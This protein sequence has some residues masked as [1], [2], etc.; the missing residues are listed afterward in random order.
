MTS[1]L[2]Q[3]SNGLATFGARQLR[4]LRRL[5]DVLLEWADACG[6]DEIA[7]PPLRPVA[8]LAR[9]DYFV[10][11]PHLGLAAAPVRHDALSGIGESVR[12]RV[13]EVPPGMLDDARY[14][15]PSAACYPVYSHLS[16]A[17]L[18][19]PRRVTTVQRC[20]RNEARYEG[21]A[22]LLAFTMREV[23]I[24]GA[25][26][27]V[28]AFLASARAWILRF[29]E[30][31]GLALSTA[32]ATDPF[33]AAAGDR[34]RMQ[35]LFPVKEEFLD[36][37]VAIASVNSHLNFFGER[38]NIRTADGAHAFSGCVAFGLERWLHALVRLCS[39]DCDAMLR[40]LDAGAHHAK[41]GDM[42]EQAG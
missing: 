16:G 34:A 7:F 28:K 29:A 32:P 11:F 9:V 5:D 12:D 19:A 38:W 40:A 39:D 1:D 35:R 24:V 22:R 13:D 27:D 14:F 4:V 31:A 15:L 25:Q 6:A 37:E 18:E 23:V 3:I 10:N 20:F 33:F 21:L 42:L 36:R 41:R 17:V 30:G 8:E 2:L 26:R